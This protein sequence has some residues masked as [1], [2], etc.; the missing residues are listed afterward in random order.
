V[1]LLMVLIAVAGVVVEHR[2]IEHFLPV[3]ARFF[4]LLGLK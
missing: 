1:A 4:N 2:V 3:S